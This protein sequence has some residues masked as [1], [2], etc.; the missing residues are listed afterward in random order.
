M[1]FWSTSG[2]DGQLDP[3]SVQNFIASLAGQLIWVNYAGSFYVFLMASS[4]FRRTVRKQIFGW[5][6]T[7]QIRPNGQT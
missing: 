3:N 2:L 4:R 5:C 6:R 7:N 1:Y